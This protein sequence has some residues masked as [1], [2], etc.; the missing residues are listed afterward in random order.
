MLAELSGLVHEQDLTV[1][2]DILT[3][4]SSKYNLDFHFGFLDTLKGTLTSLELWLSPKSLYTYW[5]KF[6][7]VKPWENVVRVVVL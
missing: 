1:L 7:A 6:G 4:V 3:D 2:T 5:Q